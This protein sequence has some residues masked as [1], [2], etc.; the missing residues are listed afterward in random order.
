MGE[1]ISV[2]VPIYN[3]EKYLEKCIS[4]IVSQTYKNLEIILVDD[5]STDQ[6]PFI[7]DEWARKD[8]RIKV[9]HKKN[10][11]NSHSRNVGLTYAA[12]DIIAFVDSDDYIEPHMYEHLINLC[13]DDIDIVECQYTFVFDDN[14][15][16]DNNNI[17]ICKEVFSSAQAMKSHIQNTIFQQVLWNKIYR[18]RVVKGVFF[19]QN[20][21]ID[22][23]FWTY[24]VIGN[25][26]KLVHIN[27]CLY[28]YRQ[29]ESSI[30]H[31]KY[32]L[33]KLQ[34]V[35]AK[36]IRHNYITKNMPTL[37]EVS[38]LN[39]IFTCIYQGQQILLYI[40]EPEQNYAIKY[41]SDILHS[42][43]IKK[44]FMSNLSIK[45]KIWIYISRKSL[46][47]TCIIRN[48]LKIGF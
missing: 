14:F 19:P 34:T 10:S 21:R 45:E 26:H 39:L 47:I 33:K 1:L 44:S 32:S 17:E 41:L 25:S 9:I 31:E 46:K 18:R 38:L 27:M 24:R 7:C 2:I 37:C 22:D 28:A 35:E 15:K 8:S 13:D 23:E 43:K 4:S 36:I 48:I 12:G 40:K 30:M 20:K 5:G 29:H 6:S 42:Y 3:E 11:G 16:F